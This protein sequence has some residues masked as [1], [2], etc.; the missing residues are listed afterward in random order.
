MFRQSPSTCVSH[1][2][3]VYVHHAMKKF[4]THTQERW[5]ESK[6]SKVNVH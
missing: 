3:V 1:L 2:I 6:K 4:N 5:E